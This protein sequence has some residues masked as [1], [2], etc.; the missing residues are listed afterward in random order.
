MAGTAATGVKLER[1]LLHRLGKAISDYALVKPGDRIAVGLSG[2]KDSFSLLDLLVKLKRKSPVPFDVMA[3]TIHNG[4]E[5]F[6]FDLVRDY[7]ES[8]GI[9]FHL[10]RTEITTIVEQKRRPGSPYCSLC[11]RLRRGALYGAVQALGCNKLA[12]GHHLDDAA[13]TL[14]MNLFFE[15]SLK[16]MPPKLLAENGRT[17]VI[18]PMTYIPESM[19]RDYAAESGFPIIDCGCWLCGE[20][21]QERARMK[22]LVEEVA[23]RYPQVRRSML[24]AMTRVEPRFLLDTDLYDFEAEE[25]PAGGEADGR[26]VTGDRR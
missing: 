3:V 22:R 25:A 23:G 4:S 16:A 13:E 15:G 20:K 2:G 9:P 24:A 5:F 19:L 11:A 8:R 18:R 26:I 1:M 10:E 6:Q 17:T 12:L 14:L 21:D 7:L